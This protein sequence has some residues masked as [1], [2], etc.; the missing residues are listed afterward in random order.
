MRGLASHVSEQFCQKLDIAV[1]T[2]RANLERRTVDGETI[3]VLDID[4]FTHTYDFPPATLLLDELYRRSDGL[5]AIVGVDEDELHVRSGH[6]LDV[7]EL[8]ETADE[9][10]EGADLEPLSTRS[11]RIEFLAG[12]RST[13]VDAM[14]D[15]IVE[16]V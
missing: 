1:E 11:H 4:R 6:E 13:V 7:R 8:V 3:G 2:A 14:L 9:A 16:R 15:A 10:V 5:T 12:Q